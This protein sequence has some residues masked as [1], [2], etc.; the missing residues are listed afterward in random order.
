MLNAVSGAQC[1]AYLEKMGT[2]D[3][4]TIAMGMRESIRKAFSEFAKTIV[5]IKETYPEMFCIMN[6]SVNC[7]CRDDSAGEYA[8]FEIGVTV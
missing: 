6:I 3:A 8:K 2:K 4:A 7:S 5:Q 1:R